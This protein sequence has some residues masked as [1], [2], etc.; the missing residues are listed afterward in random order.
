MEKLTNKQKQEINAGI[1]PMMLWVAITGACL[2]ISTLSSIA[3]GGSAQNQVDPNAATSEKG[4]SSTS[5]S[6]SFIRIS[7]RMGSSAFFLPI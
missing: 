1:G 4:T 3:K 2:A 5:A 6:N 7:P